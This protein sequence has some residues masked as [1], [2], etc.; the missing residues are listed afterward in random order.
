MLLKSPKDCG[1]ESGC[2]LLK[3][4]C[5]W[6]KDDVPANQSSES[7]PSNESSESAPTNESRGTQLC[8]M[9]LA[10]YEEMLVKIETDFLAVVL[11]DPMHGTLSGLEETVKE[12][13]KITSKRKC[14]Y[15]YCSLDNGLQWLH[16]NR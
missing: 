8:E 2:T 6:S 11:E 12:T 3:L 5:Y 10:K 7:A 1:Y 13:E 16:L 14:C 15:H 4:Y 9:L